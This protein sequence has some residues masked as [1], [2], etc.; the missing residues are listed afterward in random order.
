VDDNGEAAMDGLRR[1]AAN[2]PDGKL[3]NRWTLHVGG[4]I[5]AFDLDS[6]PESIV[7]KVN[8]ATKLLGQKEL[9][10]GDLKALPATM[11]TRYLNLFNPVPNGTAAQVSE[12]KEYV[13]KAIMQGDEQ[14]IADMKRAYEM[15]LEAKQGRD[16][17]PHNGRPP[18]YIPMEDEKG[19]VT[20][21]V[22][23]QDPTVTVAA[24]PGQRRRAL[25]MQENADRANFGTL[26][27]QF[28]GLRN[29]IAKRK[30]V[31]GPAAGRLGTLQAEWIGGDPDAA[32]A[33]Q[34][35]DDIANQLIYLASGKQINE[36]EFKR[37]KKTF[38]HK[39]LPYDTFMVR[40]NN[41]QD[42]M[43]SIYRLRTGKE[44][45]KGPLPSS[46]SS[47]PPPQQTQGKPVLVNGKVVGYTTDGKTMTPVGGAQ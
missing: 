21:W 7:G 9:A 27:G 6:S 15:V 8:R 29:I 24:K 2:S 22:N 13:A 38:P 46:Q 41:F 34:K 36:E 16:T 45:P 30:E 23:N 4:K 3:G 33:Y 35:M 1:G 31:V 25:P 17:K 28:Q 20:E 39:N 32:D 37:L 26:A 14:N 18:V 12:Y 47:T 11:K 44:L 19:N 42:R 43:A 10:P 40:L 5:L